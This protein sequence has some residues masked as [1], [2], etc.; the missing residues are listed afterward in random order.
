M[1]GVDGLGQEM[2]E[3]TLLAELNE[4]VLRGTPKSR[5]RALWHTTDLL[6][7]GRYSEADVWTFGEVIG[8]LADEIETAARAQL[9]EKL[10]RFDHAPVNIVRKLAF[11]HAIE[12]ARPVLEESRQLDSDTLIAATRSSSQ[13][14]MLAISRR[15][16]IDERVTDELVTRGNQEV[17]QSLAR[18]SG[19]RLSDFGFLHLIKR[20]AGDNIL[21]EQLGLRKDISR[22]LFQQL[23]AKASDEVRKRLAQA[24]PEMFDQIQTSV[25][26]VAG[27][28][29]AKLGPVSR[30]YFVA[31]RLVTAQHQNGNLNEASISGYAR[32]HKFDEV[33]IAMSLLCGMPPDVIERALMDSNGEMVL[34]LAKALDFSWDTTMSLLFLGAKDHRISARDLEVK[35]EEYKCLA[36]DASRSVL[37]LYRT[38]KSGDVPE[39][40]RLKAAMH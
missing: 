20:S 28:L 5:L 17:V 16:S 37:K 29:H 35:E 13:A 24:N 15:R 7:T 21:A 36:V 26:E 39:P 10:A 22:H 6:I 3:T 25:A 11:D 8:R 2:T 14:H 40:P 23:V 31:K 12:V 27:A 18:N 38:R 34:V 19:A 1:R 30:G 32:S 4:A 33:T 9:A